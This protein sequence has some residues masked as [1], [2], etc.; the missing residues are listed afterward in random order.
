MLKGKIKENSDLTV[1]AKY[2]EGFEVEI[3]YLSRDQLRKIMDQCKKTD[4][5]PKTHQIKES[6]D[7]DKFYR[8]QAEHVVVD[9]RGLT[10]PVLKNIVDMEPY[11][12]T[13]VPYSVEDCA[14]LLSKAYDF[15]LWVQQISSDLEYFEASRRA[16]EVKNS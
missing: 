7:S 16:S 1:W 3:R 14:E 4:W 10:P 5:D 15:D 8:Q 6:L 11:P 2:K 13:E 9:W 12:E